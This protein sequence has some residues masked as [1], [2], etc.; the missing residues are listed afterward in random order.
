MRFWKRKTVVARA[1]M[2]ACKECGVYFEPRCY[3]SFQELCAPHRDKKLSIA[4]D[5]ELFVR[6]ALNNMETLRE[7]A[8]KWNNEY[9]RMT[10][11]AF[12][13]DRYLRGWEKK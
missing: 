1:A 3:G 8:V 4:Y 10:W 9:N 11:T 12:G 13:V 2:V 7:D 5:E 6:Y